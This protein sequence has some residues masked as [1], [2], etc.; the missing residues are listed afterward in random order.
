MFKSRRLAVVFVPV[1]LGAISLPLQAAPVTQCGP[2][3]CYEYDDAQPAAGIG[4]DTYGLPS[5]VGDALIFQPFE[6]R[7]ESQNGAGLDTASATFVFDRVYSISGAEIM[8]I[9]IGE[10][11]DYR[12][13]V[14]D[15][16]SDTLD[17]LIENNNSAESGSDTSIFSASGDSG[18]QQQEWEINVSYDPSALFTTTGKDVKLT[19]TNTLEADTDADGEMAWIQKKLNVTVTAVPLPATVWLLGSGLGL[20]GWL[21]RKGKLRA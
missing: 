15:G 5:L 1:F 14:G 17:I 8:E 13:D 9:S 3:I 12:I 20:L 19:I 4:V 16:V 6:F 2:T 7:A 21:R 18:G 10:F 11:G